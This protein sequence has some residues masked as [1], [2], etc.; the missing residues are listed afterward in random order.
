M[1]VVR[2]P[3]TFE[4]SFDYNPRVIADIKAIPGHRWNPV[5]KLWT[6]P[7]DQEASVQRLMKKHSAATVTSAGPEEYGELPEMP[8]LDAEIPLK[9]PLFT[10]QGKGV[11]QGL[12][13]KRFINGDEPGLGKTFQSI[14]TIIAADAFPVLIVCPSSLK[15]NW[16]KEWHDKAG[17]KSIIL[18]DSVNNT[19]H[20]YYKVGMIKV[21][22]TNY[23]SLKKYF[24]LRIN[25]KENE[26]LRL[27]HIELKETVNLFRAV[28][29]DELHKCK[30]GRT[31][32]SKFVMGICKGKE[33]VLG[34]TGTPVVNKPK[35]LISQLHVI[36][37]LQD[38]GGYK[39][40]LDRYCGGDG[41][42][43]NNL[44]ELN[45][46]LSSMCF[47]R[48]TKKEVLKD[49]PDKMRQ[50]VI[51]DI[52]TRKEYN[53]ALR[54]LAD[55]LKQYRSKTESEIDKSMRGEI[56]VKIGICKNISARGKMEAAMEAIDEVIEAGQKI[57]VF[58]HQRE[59][60]AALK[61]HYPGAKT[62]TGA[63]SIDSRQ[64]SVDAFQNDPNIKVIICS[65]KAAGVGLTLTASSRVLF[66]EQ[67]WHAADE[68]QC[69]D[70]C[71]RIGQHDSV[72]CMTLLGK[73]TI[74]EYIYELIEKKRS[75]ANKV[76]GNTSYVEKE[77]IDRVMNSL[78][79]TQTAAE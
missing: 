57:V 68:E 13:F 34:L 43:A 19:W 14:A 69:E 41:K 2:T 39:R 32:Q 4:I 65:I 30:D 56:M 24:V 3:T 16:A 21:F 62:I 6:L 60:A 7:Q 70:R 45:Y 51:C 71:H 61:A 74:D 47:Y 77:I 1:Q 75:M 38:M 35:D 10:F 33:Y 11:A 42:G 66:I 15:E 53:D 67:P 5:K 28:I 58:I 29:V 50:V 72:H 27:K 54:D 17:I 46:K 9:K 52:T 63:D 40:F 48:R 22:I 78:F 23:E 26:A 55:Y 12:R 36:D 64:A 18:R 76:T 59:I 8:D 25:K 20:Q 44:N 73:D 79:N 49:L 37:R 31:Q